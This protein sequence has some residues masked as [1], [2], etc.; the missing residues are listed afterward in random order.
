MASGSA[1]TGGR[2]VPGFGAGR[3]TLRTRVFSDGAQALYDVSS[4][5]YEGHTCPLMGFGHN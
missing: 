5:Y 2:R 4:S 3:D 1:G